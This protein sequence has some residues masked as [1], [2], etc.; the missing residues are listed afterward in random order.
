MLW[1]KFNPW[2]KKVNIPNLSDIQS[3]LAYISTVKLLQE[4]KGQKNCLYL[5]PPIH[6]YA[7]LDFHKSDEIAKVGYEHTMKEIEKWR[8]QGTIAPKQ[9][10]KTGA[11]SPPV[12]G[13]PRK[14]SM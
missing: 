7:T 1:K 4:V 9:E 12:I 13:R 3:Q 11:P 8:E 6:T 2:T 14:L 10:K 5:R